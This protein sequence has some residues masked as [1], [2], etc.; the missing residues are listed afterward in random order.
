VV[1]TV[2]GAVALIGGVAARIEAGS[3]APKTMAICPA[4]ESACVNAKTIHVGL[5]H[6]AYD[7]L[8]I[9]SYALLIVGVL[10]VL[11]GLIAYWAQQRLRPSN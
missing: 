7:L 8:R 2:L 6:T 3:H 9:G 1:R 10:L 4:T 11:T 5:S